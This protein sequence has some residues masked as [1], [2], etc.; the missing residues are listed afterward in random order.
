VAAGLA[1]LVRGLVAPGTEL[2]AGE[3]V[4]DIDPRGPEVDPSR[5][6]DKAVAIGNGVLAGLAE[7]GLAPGSGR[8]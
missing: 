6:S 5:I 7:A 2:S 1:G 4:G 8:E 3:K